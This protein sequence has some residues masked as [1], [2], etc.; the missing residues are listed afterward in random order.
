MKN[1]ILP[2][3]VL[4]ASAAFARAGDPLPTMR[5]VTYGSSVN[6]VK[7]KRLEQLKELIKQGADV[8]APIGF[9]RMLNEGE[10]PVSSSRTEPGEGVA[11]L[12]RIPLVLDW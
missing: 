9:N 12:G 10:N 6:A 7:M 4:L 2:V 1:T 11:E 5:D 8:N 3:A